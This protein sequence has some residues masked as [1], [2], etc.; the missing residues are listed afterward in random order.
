MLGIYTKAFEEAEYKSVDD[1]LNRPDLEDADY[2]PL[3]WKESVLDQTI[4]RTRYADF[5]E[6][7]HRLLLVMGLTDFARLYA[8]RLNAASVLRDCLTGAVAGFISHTVS[9]SEKYYMPHHVKYNLAEKLYKGLASEEKPLFDFLAQFSMKRDPEVPIYA[10]A[11]R[12]LSIQGRRDVTA[13][14]QQIEVAKQELAG[15]HEEAS[16]VKAKTALARHQA[17]LRRLLSALS[18]LLVAKA[19]MEC[20]AE[21]GRL[22]ARGEPTDHLRSPDQRRRGPHSPTPPS[23]PRSTC[24][25]CGATFSR[26]HELTRLLHVGKLRESEGKT[27]QAQSVGTHPMGTWSKHTSLDKDMPRLTCIS[28]AHPS[29][30][31]LDMSRSLLASVQSSVSLFMARQLRKRTFKDDPEPPGPPPRR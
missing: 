25:L 29:S 19:R 13:L 4:F 9:T 10:T 3:R 7:F 17:A 12:M 16:R 8:L 22:R 24:F 23:S 18:D 5:C 14:R 27:V 21:A 15:S 28:T 30:I 1:M 11:E 6:V 20:C 26:P 31:S 2:V